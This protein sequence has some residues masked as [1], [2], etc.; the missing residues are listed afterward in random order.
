M[1]WITSGYCV[2]AVALVGV[3]ALDGSRRLQV[4]AL[5]LLW[6]GLEHQVGYCGLL[7]WGCCCLS[8][9]LDDSRELQAVAMDYKWL[10]CCC[11]GIGGSR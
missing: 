8:Y 5:L 9:T 11:C 10:P 2:A 3:D 7:A 6:Y 1:Q 4:A